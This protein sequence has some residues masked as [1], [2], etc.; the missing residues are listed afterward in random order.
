MLKPPRRDM[1]ATTADAMWVS[2]DEDGAK[3]LN[4]FTPRKKTRK[5][6]TPHKHSRT[7][8]SGS[9]S[10]HTPG[11]PGHHGR[12]SSLE[13]DATYF[14]PHSP[15][16]IALANGTQAAPRTPPQPTRASAA[17]AGR[18]PLA[19]PS[20]RPRQH[21]H[22]GEHS[23]TTTPLPYSHQ[24]KHR[25]HDASGLDSHEPQRPTDHASRHHA[26]HRPRRGGTGKAEAKQHQPKVLLLA[27]ASMMLFLGFQAI[28]GL[29][30]IAGHPL[31]TPAAL[32]LLT[33]QQALAAR[34]AK[35]TT[36]HPRDYA[37]PR[38]R[39]SCTALDGVMCATQSRH[40]R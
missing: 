2:D 17:A 27:V 36:R 24:H 28:Q 35:Q 6:R 9:S 11:K 30:D 5:D 31:V 18:P 22:H 7:P 12:S 14:V 4:S 15:A 23:P 39:S 32:R 40:E 25:H 29:E 38:S 16:L 1:S 20:G 37:P 21:P 3:L 34:K 8:R 19:Q 13:S 10:N 26:R 33:P